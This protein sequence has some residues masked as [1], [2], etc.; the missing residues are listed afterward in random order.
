MPAA[1]VDQEKARLIEVLDATR[2]EMLAVLQ[3]VSSDLVVHPKTNW[4]MRDI[5]AHLTA[6]EQE[7]VT[8]LVA[9]QNG[10]TYVITGFSNDDEYNWQAYLKWFDIPFEQLYAEWTAVRE[11]LKTALSAT[12]PEKFPGDMVHPWWSPGTVI[13]LILSMESHEREHMEEIRR[14]VQ[15]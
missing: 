2:Q 12:T 1:N 5:L 15:S 6:W 13:D 14:A 3:G 11:R 4:R 7:A 8:S 9:Y 10:E